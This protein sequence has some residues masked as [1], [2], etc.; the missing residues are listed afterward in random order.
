MNRNLHMLDNNSGIIPVSVIASFNPY[1]QIKPLYFQYEDKQY[2]ITSVIRSNE[3]VTKIIFSCIYLDMDSELENRI[4]LIYRI[5]D[6]I[7]GIVREF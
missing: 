2:K 6:Q 5:R 7:W 4:T 1:G 3:E